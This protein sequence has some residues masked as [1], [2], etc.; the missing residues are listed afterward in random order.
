MTIVDVS[1]I[2]AVVAAVLVVIA[3]VYTLAGVLTRQAGYYISFLCDNSA[4]VVVFILVLAAL[5]GA[6]GELLHP[7][8]ISAIRHIK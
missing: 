7:G 4:D 6:A 1:N 5:V 2:L 8:T 3:I